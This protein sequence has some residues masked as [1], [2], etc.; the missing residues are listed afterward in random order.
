MVDL[1][2][3]GYSVWVT[4]RTQFGL[5]GLFRYDSLDTNRDLRP[6]P[7]RERTI[8][9]IAYWPPLQGGK[10]VAFLV[11]YEQLKI[12]NVTPLV[13]DTRIYALHTLFNF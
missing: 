10:S 7:R 1:K 8:A 11:D 13:A 3:A 6:K 5:E 9:G 12:K 4:P 2:R